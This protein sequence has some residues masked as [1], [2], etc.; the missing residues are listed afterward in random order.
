MQSAQ[1]KGIKVLVAEDDPFVA[2][3]VCEFASA[4]GFEA[5]HASD[6]EKALAI[7][8]SDPPAVVLLDISLP[9]LDGRDVLA[10]LKRASLLDE[11]V[12]LFTTARDSQI[13][14]LNGLTL[15]AD[16]YETKPFRLTTLFNKIDALVEKKLGN[17]VR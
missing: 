1:E 12:V 14:R 13:D 16:D 5:I 4:R 11:M 3:S 17:K 15:G 10:E 6:G 8:R 9:R 7:C 2:H